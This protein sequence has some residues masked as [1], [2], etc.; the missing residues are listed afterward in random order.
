MVVGTG[1]CLSVLG[2]SMLVSSSDYF[3]PETEPSLTP[4][5]PTSTADGGAPP[6]A[7]PARLVFMGGE[8][9]TAE[10][11]RSKRPGL[12]VGVAPLDAGAGDFTFERQPP[13]S[14]GGAH[15]LTREVGGSLVA[16]SR[17]GSSGVFAE[18]APLVGAGL[19][20]WTAHE[21]PSPPN[22]GQA[23]LAWAGD[24][25]LAFDAGQ[26]FVASFDARTLAVGEWRAFAEGL[27]LP[28]TDRSV[29][30]VGEWLFFVGGT[31]S[32]GAPSAEIE[33]FSIDTT[34]GRV[35]GASRVTTMPTA[36]EHPC[37][38]AADG[39]LHVMGSFAIHVADV[40]TGGDAPLGSWRST[41]PASVGL[42]LLPRRPACAAHE[43]R[44]YWT[45]DFGVLF[46]APSGDAGVPS[47]LEISGGRISDVGFVSRG[48]LVVLPPR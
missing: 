32:D 36:L 31:K 15:L 22:A 23:V 2:C 3:R 40:A 39:R 35:R 48:Q 12:E 46:S 6:A 26:H 14:F 13:A 16:I 5:V 9:T 37:V 42:T 28:L 45:G 43:G 44:L 20:D 18:V 21:L 19:G 10:A 41:P 11:A 34:Q 24:F 47:P 27:T 17:V 29:A 8:A 25:L 1:F 38:V 30:V 7:V 4:P 33:L